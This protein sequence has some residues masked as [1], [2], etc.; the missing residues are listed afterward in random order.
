MK[1]GLFGKDGA[2]KSVVAS[3]LATYYA[4]DAY[5][6][7][8]LEGL[9]NLLPRAREYDG[10]AVPEPSLI[11]FPFL[12]RSF[13]LLARDP[14]VQVALVTTPHAH[15]VEAAKGVLETLRRYC[16]NEVKGVVLNQGA[17]SLGEDIADKL[18][19]DLLGALPLEPELDAY[20]IRSGII[21]GYT[22][23]AGMLKALGEL[24]GNLGLE[25]REDAQKEKRL[26]SLLKGVWLWRT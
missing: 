13:H 21:A 3:L 8:P 6:A 22:P 1:I 25:A 16:P 14:D 19:L 12:E 7:D 9:R 4:V 2:G 11:D 10:A 20:L 23:G 17:R 18:D 26:G 15:A 5:D 24:A